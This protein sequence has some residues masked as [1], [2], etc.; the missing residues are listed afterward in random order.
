MSHGNI[1]VIIDP[2]I[3][4]MTAQPVIQ[5]IV[6]LLEKAGRTCYK[7]ESKITDA[8]A[9]KFVTNIIK[10]GHES[11]IEHASITVRFIC[12]RSTSHQLVRHRIAAYSQESQRFCDYGKKGLQ[13]IL[14][15]S[16]GK[17][18]TGFYKSDGVHWQHES[19][20]W[21]LRG[22]DALL[23]SWINAI[24][25]CYESYLLLRN[26]RVLPEDARSVLPNCT[27]TEVVT[28]FNLRQW[29]HV[30]ADRALNPAAQWQIR[31]LMSQTLEA[32]A[33][34]LPCIFGDQLEALK[35]VSV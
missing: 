23:W 8:S 24:G 29:R 15:P 2:S 10:S 16:I 35:K 26:N 12:D 27:K 21:I 17:L 14:P 28:T 5:H 11:V 31:N 1:I 34:E 22:R 18:P 20:Q 33:Q 25:N 3:E 7:S 19:G 6:S 30:F 4:I 9:E 32:F 13:V